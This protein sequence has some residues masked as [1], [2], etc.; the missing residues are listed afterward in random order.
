MKTKQLELLAEW[1]GPKYKIIQD[2]IVEA[3]EKMDSRTIDLLKE[4][5]LKEAN[6]TRIEYNKMN[7]GW[8]QAQYDIGVREDCIESEGETIKD[9]DLNAIFNYVKNKQGE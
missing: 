3:L 8:W 2:L 4:K 6:I 9:A 7:S 5:F 1:I